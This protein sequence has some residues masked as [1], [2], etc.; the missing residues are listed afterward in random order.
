MEERPLP[1]TNTTRYY[2]SGYISKDY[3]EIILVPLH[4]EFPE[5]LYE[6]WPVVV[7]PLRTLPVYIG[8]AVKAILLESIPGER[9]KN[10]TLLK[11]LTDFPQGNIFVGKSDLESISKQTHF[12][13]TYI[14]MSGYQTLKAQTFKDFEKYYLPLRIDADAT[15][16]QVVVVFN[17]W[18]PNQLTQ[19][20]PVDI[21]E[22]KL[23]GLILSYLELF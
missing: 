6:R 23:G 15:E 16:I 3:D 21:E 9:G 17:E 5:E 20:V 4:E 13:K 22:N 14:N 12:G 2:A 7:L 18:H 10:K 11:W 1:Q 8:Q 19:A